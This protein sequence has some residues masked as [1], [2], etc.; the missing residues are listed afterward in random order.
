MNNGALPSKGL[1][2]RNPW[3]DLILSGRKTW[4]MRSKPTSIR[5]EIA[6]IRAGSGLVCGVATLVDCLPPLSLEELRATT[7]FH[8]IPDSELEEAYKRGWNTPWVLQDVKRL[9]PP[10][11]YEHP[12]EAVVWVNLSDSGRDDAGNPDDVDADDPE[13]RKLDTSMSP[14]ATAAHT[15]AG[16][17]VTGREWVEI[18][19]TDANVEHGHIYLRTAEH[20]FPADCIGGSKRSMAGRY[21]RVRFNPGTVVETDIDGKKMILRNRSSQRDFFTRTGTKGG[22]IVRITRT[23]ER[24]FTIAMADRAGAST[25]EIS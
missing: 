2:I 24:E 15:S 22:D 19:L 9:D 5:G 10:V 14:A 7:S 18:R 6:L 3:I 1:V 16:R 11:P 8:A 13:S 17:E 12:S 23:S 4:E 21:I 20:L 25:P